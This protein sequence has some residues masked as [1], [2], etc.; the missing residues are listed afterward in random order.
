ME[1]PKGYCQCGCGQKTDII[2]RNHVSKGQK[3]GEYF[4]FLPR[5]HRHC[6]STEK[7]L[8]EAGEATGCYVSHGYINVYDKEHPS[9]KPVSESR[10]I[11]ESK[12][13]RFLNNDECVFHLDGDRL[14]TQ[15]LVLCK[16]GSYPSILLQRRIALEACGNPNYRKCSKCKMYDD[17]K[18]MIRDGRANRSSWRHPSHARK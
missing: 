4:R 12:I 14:S 10:L 2:K 9:S 7:R 13:G 8:N 3:K 17:P 11:V 16:K 5:H 15:N 18:N 6:P 1:I